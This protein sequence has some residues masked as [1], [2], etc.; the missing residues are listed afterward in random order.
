MCFSNDTPQ[1]N[2]GLVAR[3]QAVERE[4]RVTQGRE[5][6]D[7]QFGIFDPEYFQNYQ[8]AYV[9]N[10]NPQVD[11]Q[12]TDARK[13]LRYNLARSGTIDSTPGQESFGDLATSY[14]NARRD[15]ASR[16]SDATNQLRGEIDSARGDLYAQNSASAD[17][18]LASIQAVSRTGSLTTPASYS[19][20]GDLFSGIVGGTGAYLNGRNAGL[21]DGYRDRFAPGATLPRSGSGRVVT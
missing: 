21:P 5:A 18:S 13:K 10:Y 8:N 1:D 7:R 12:F 9:S 2:S 14:Q 3:Q 20:L 16:A 19:P 6:I 11:E 4:G 17:P 15:V